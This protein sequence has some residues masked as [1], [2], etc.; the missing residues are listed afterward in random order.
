MKSISSK[1]F[2]S[3]A[4]LTSVVLIATLLLTR[5]SFE[6]DFLNYVN[7]LE[8]RRLTDMAEELA[9]HYVNNNSDWNQ[10]SPQT[11]SRI[12]SKWTPGDRPIGGPRPFSRGKH[13]RPPPPP[14]PRSGLGSPSKRHPTILVNNDG[15]YIAGQVS[16]PKSL[17]MVRVKVTVGSNVIG[18]LRTVAELFAESSLETEFSKQQTRANILISVLSLILAGL[19]SWGL[20]RLLVAPVLQMKRGIVKLANGDYSSRLVSSRDDEMGALMFG[21]NR[22]AE[23]LEENRSSRKRLLADI[24]H[25]LRTPVTILSGEIE[26]IKD[27]LRPMDMQQLESLDHEVGRLRHSINDLY[28]L[29]L[30]DIG[31]LRYEF[32]SLDAVLLLENVLD[33][34][35]TRL[36]QAELTASLNVHDRTLIDAD[37]NRLEQLFTNLLNNS[38]AYTDK[39]GELSISVASERDFLII[40]FNDSAPGVSSTAFEEM[41]D[42]LYREDESRTRRVSGA[43]LGLTICKNI[44]IA[45]QGQINACAS[46]LGGVGIRLELPIGLRS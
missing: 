26:A 34:N 9:E 6:R 22:L 17:Y 39:G 13:H 33:Q 42:P 10:I 40:E 3:L 24:S 25:E 14:P 45:H 11:F 16:L 5:W 21:I 30:S 31:G 23:T 32:V 20:M 2:F 15:D 4:G 27:G 1:L 8:Q 19:A 12:F 37:A 29:S 43:G 44:V 38:I 28:E 36:E 46:P 41:F 18:E 35:Q 7:A